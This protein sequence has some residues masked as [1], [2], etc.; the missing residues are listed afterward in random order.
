M[1][2]LTFSTGVVD[3]VCYLGLDRV[4]TANM[5]GNVVILGMGL[6]GADGLSVAGPLLALAGFMTGAAVGGRILRSSAATWTSRTTAALCFVALVVASV[7]IG[8]ATIAAFDAPNRSLALSVTALLGS[9]MGLQAATARSLAVPDVTTV[10]VTATV[11]H[12]SSDVTS[13]VAEQGASARR[14]LA[15]GLLL[16]GAAVGALLLHW[17]LAAGLSL[18]A[19]TCVVVAAIGVSAHR[20]LENES[21]G[22]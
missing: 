2:A 12:L 20:R 4:F 17:H 22:D 1:L 7:A 5:T 10:A 19:A 6:A 13:G 21:V 14:V 16:A 11:I 15:I 9:A 8:S 3:A 18:A